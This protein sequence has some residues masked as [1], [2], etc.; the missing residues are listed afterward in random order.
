HP[1]L[2]LYRYPLLAVVH[3]RV[4]GRRGMC[5]LGDPGIA[6]PSTTYPGQLL[7]RQGTEAAARAAR[8]AALT[9]ANST[10]ASKSGESVTRS[11]AARSR[12]RPRKP[13]PP[14]AMRCAKSASGSETRRCCTSVLYGNQNGR[15]PRKEPAAGRCGRYWDRTSDLLGV[16]E[17]L[18]R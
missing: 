5:F 7:V 1:G 14:P 8:R 4:I 3:E 2:V 17:A 9:L 11:S 12:P 16:N 13:R 10:L 6:G 15:F 18:S